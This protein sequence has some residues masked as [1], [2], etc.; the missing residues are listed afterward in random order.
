MPSDVQY[1]LLLISS[2][3]HATF[4]SSLRHTRFLLFAT[5]SNSMASRAVGLITSFLERCADRGVA[6]KKRRKQKHYSE[7][8]KIWDQRLPRAHSSSDDYTPIVHPAAQTE[9]IFFSKLPLEI[10]QHIYSYA[11]CGHELEP[12]V[13]RDN[14]EDSKPKP[15]DLMCP[16]VQ[17]LRGFLVSC[18]QA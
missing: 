15:F 14:I 13:A 2:H 17:Q 4:P 1:A 18:K 3:I 16:A 12:R 7:Q 8:A 9:A 11:F 10:R 6:N 5:S